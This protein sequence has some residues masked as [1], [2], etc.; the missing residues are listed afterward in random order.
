MMEWPL[1]TWL[2][3]SPL[4]GAL[5][6]L[7]LPG[8]FHAALRLLALASS[9]WTLTLAV[10]A[11]AALGGP[12]AAGLVHGPL[13]WWLA[14]YHVRVDGASGGLALLTAALTPLVVLSTWRQIATQV[15]GFLVCL[16]LLEAGLFTTFLARDLFL[17]YCGW[18]L[19]LVPMYFI[20]GLWGGRRRLYATTK[21]VVF[22]AAGSL[23]MLAAILVLAHAGGGWDFS[24]ESAPALARR[25][26][27]AAQGWALAAFL[28][29]FAV[30]I[31]VWPLHTWLPDAHVEAPAGGSIF[32]AGV[33]L[34]MGSYALARI[35]LPIFAD[36]AVAFLPWLAA[37]GA[38]GAVWGG[39]MSLAQGDIKS[40]VAYSSVSHMAV[41]VLGIAAGG[42][43]GM[44]GAFFQMLAHGVNTGCLFLLVGI[45]YERTHS[46]L[47]ADHGGL[48][49][50]M[51]VFA[52][53]FLVASLSS[54]GLPGL[55]GFPGEFLI[56]KGVLASWSQT[57]SPLLLAAFAAAGAGLFLSASYLLWMYKR[58]FFGPLAFPH[59]EGRGGSADHAPADLTLR[60]KIVAGSLVA[61][62]VLL[63]LSPNLFLSRSE[64]DTAAITRALADA[65]GVR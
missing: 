49:K 15:K 10:Q 4:A 42:S 14:S 20:I 6:V 36:A 1:A 43:A 8:G 13:P 34:K 17:F 21:F 26:S 19:V 44:Q 38:I 2:V 39:L 29:A 3:L 16:L 46:R 23:L 56:L 12:D 35:A 9:A 11:F 65:R 64:P 24:M 63:G 27:P 25:L 7:A 47:V 45:L 59:Q 57:R 58:V 54:L 41:I 28:A 31:P 53:L 61:A 33:L 60:E 37:L 32:L 50:A 18:E 62:M 55:A 51:P 22:T 52:A 40:L 5:A 48:A 30:K